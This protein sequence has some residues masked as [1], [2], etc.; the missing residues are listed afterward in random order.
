MATAQKTKDQINFLKVGARN[1]SAEKL[2]R[3]NLGGRGVIDNLPSHLKGRTVRQFSPHHCE[4]YSEYLYQRGLMIA[5]IHRERSKEANELKRKAEVNGL[6]FIPQINNRS[7]E[8]A[9]DR[10]PLLDRTSD[11][12]EKDRQQVLSRR[13]RSYRKSSAITQSTTKKAKQKRKAR[14]VLDPE[15]HDNFFRKNI[16]WLQHKENKIDFLQTEKKRREEIEDLRSMVPIK[17]SDDPLYQFDDPAYEDMYRKATQVEADRGL[18]KVAKR[19]GF[20]E[21]ED[22]SIHDDDKVLAVEG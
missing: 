21:D 3:K 2:K 16:E 7:R 9:R 17:F 15:D 1:S 14:V 13:S 4:N 22:I 6:S 11:L 10:A 20:E 19:L 12:I 8:L 5:Q 18:A